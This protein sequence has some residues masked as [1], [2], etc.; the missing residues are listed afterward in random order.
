MPVAFELNPFELVIAIFNERWPNKRV[1][2]EE[3]RRRATWRAGQPN[4]RSV[5]KP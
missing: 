2:H 3:A 5:R 1:R 4:D